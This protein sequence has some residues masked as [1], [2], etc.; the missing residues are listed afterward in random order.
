[1]K[2]SGSRGF[3][4]NPAGP[5]KEHV[6][7]KNFEVSTTEGRK[8]EICGYGKGVIGLFHHTLQ[9]YETREKESR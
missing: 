8:K 6:K 2:L 5:E 3:G 1:M 4:S 9:G 7:K